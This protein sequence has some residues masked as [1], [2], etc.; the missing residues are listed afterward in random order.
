VSEGL[1]MRR[2]ACGNA[3]GFHEYCREC[4]ATSGGEPFPVVPAAEAQEATPAM[5]REGARA[6]DAWSDQT[7][8]E[9]VDGTE[10]AARV[11]KA[12]CST[13]SP[14]PEERGRTGHE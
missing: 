8:R 2:C 7:L 10:M 14:H 4:G 5:L 3:H 1:M 11:W 6:L 9:T 12:M 13:L